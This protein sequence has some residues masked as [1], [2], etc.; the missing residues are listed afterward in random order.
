MKSKILESATLGKPSIETGCQLKSAAD[1]RIIEIL[2]RM[3]SGI[4]ELHSALHNYTAS[5]VE[6]KRTY[7]YRHLFI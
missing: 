4:I 3:E 7:N 2:E 1:L 5:K 6:V